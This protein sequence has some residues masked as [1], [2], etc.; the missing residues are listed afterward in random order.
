M[1]GKKRV[2]CR[3]SEIER[4]ISVRC[5]GFGEYI[6]P[7][8]VTKKVKTSLVEGVSSKNNREID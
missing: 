2:E 5:R 8:G 6:W 1:Q 4:D 7:V 3:E